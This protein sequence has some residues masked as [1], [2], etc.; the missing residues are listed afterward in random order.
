MA[1]VK[2][3][4]ASLMC[5]GNY[6]SILDYFKYL[7]FKLTNINSFFFF[8]NKTKLQDLRRI[9]D[10]VFFYLMNIIFF[11]FHYFSIK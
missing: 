3:N 2:E 5:V 6:F 10:P 7:N 4:C 8:W 1:F 9:I 11:S